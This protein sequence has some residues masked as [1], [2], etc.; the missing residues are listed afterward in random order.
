MPGAF[1]MTNFRMSAVI[2]GLLSLT[3]I[4]LKSDLVFLFFLGQIVLQ[5]QLSFSSEVSQSSCSRSS[6][7]EA[8]AVQQETVIESLEDVTLVC[9]T[10][11]KHGLNLPSALIPLKATVISRGCMCRIRKP[12]RTAHMFLGLTM[13]F[14]IVCF[15]L[16]CFS[17]YLV[18]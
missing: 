10:Q 15:S 6:Q 17:V 13:I 3:V 8:S 12:F 1:R 4:A 16:V 11:A 9:S 18:Q 5:C 7:Q 14:K 2:Q